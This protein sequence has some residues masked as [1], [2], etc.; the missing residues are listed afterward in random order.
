MKKILEDLDS[1]VMD[2]HYKVCR[3]NFG[4]EYIQD[5][6]DLRDILETTL[7]DYKELEST[8]GVSQ[9]EEI[10]KKYKYWDYFKEQNLKELEDKL[11]EEREFPVMYDADFTYNNL[12]KEIKSIIKSIK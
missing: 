9:W 4:V 7:K 6:S 8:M 12:L 5:S 10:G 11:P 3:I 1:K 2:W